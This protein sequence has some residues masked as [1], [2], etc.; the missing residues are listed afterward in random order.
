ML[1]KE[2]KQAITRIGLLSIGWPVGLDRFYDG[3]NKD[4]ILSI[5][6]WALIFGAIL[7]LSPCHGYDYNNSVK[8]VSDMSINP[9]IILPLG[10]GV[11]GGILVLKKGFRLLKQ[12]ENAT[13]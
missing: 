12:F 4:G 8:E 11:Y 6:G 13:D 10:F 5:I 7:F 3:K 1:R 2:E 9:L